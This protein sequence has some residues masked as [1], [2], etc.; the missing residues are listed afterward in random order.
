MKKI[1][2]RT[3][4]TFPFK[5]RRK[6]KPDLLKSISP[7]R[8]R[9][10][11]EMSSSAL[12]KKIGALTSEQRIE[13]LSALT[14]MDLHI[15]TWSQNFRCISN[16]YSLFRKCHLESVYSIEA[17]QNI[18]NESKISLSLPHAQV[19]TGFS[20]RV[21]D[22]MAS[23]SMLMSNPSE[24]LIRLFDGTVPTFD[25]ARELKD[26]CQYFLKNEA[27]RTDIVKA[28]QKLIDNNHRYENVFNIIEDYSGMKLLNAGM[29]RPPE[30]FSRTKTK[31]QRWLRKQ[32]NV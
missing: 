27:E 13:C 9:I 14:D 10:S 30:L 1:S 5:F 25:S 18:Y 12:Q 26:K 6:N 29:A 22:I 16:Y 15:Y 31:Q 8:T 23:N 3:I 2:V 32:K 17:S 21:C 20:W 24:D 19:N 11:D 7:E 4:F 28:C